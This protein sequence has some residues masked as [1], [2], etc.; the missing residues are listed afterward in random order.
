LRFILTSH[1]LDLKLKRLNTVT[2]SLD[3]VVIC[4]YY[5]VF[6]FRSAFIE[7]Y[8]GTCKHFPAHDDL[9]ETRYAVMRLS[10]SS[11]LLASSAVKRHFDA[12]LIEMMLKSLKTVELGF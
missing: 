6:I 10:S 7:V 2:E 5:D 4:I 1:S 11:Y 3:I 9:F 8:L 12:F